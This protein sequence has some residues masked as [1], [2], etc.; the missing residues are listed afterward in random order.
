LEKYKKSEAIFNR[1]KMTGLQL[2]NP[3]FN[4]FEK[5]YIMLRSF[6]PCC[7]LLMLWLPYVSYSQ[8]VGIKINNPAFP[9]DVNGDLNIRSGLR[10]EGS[11]GVSGAVL[12]SRGELLPPV[13]KA[14]HGFKAGAANN[15]T[16]S[17]ANLDQYVKIDFT[18]LG[19]GSRF[20]YGNG[21]NTSTSLYTVQEPG[22]YLLMASVTISNCPAGNFRFGIRTTSGGNYTS[23]SYTVSTAGLAQT[24]TSFGTAFLEEGIELGAYISDN[25]VDNIT[26]FNGAATFLTIVKMN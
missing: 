25:T 1:R 4:N 23:N 6:F 21:Y 15:Q 3:F 20:T 16:I 8:N 11:R 12:T 10:I 26:T 19:S 5:K 2:S 9:L 17:S 14:F 18:S 24:F 13:W 22:V 7:L